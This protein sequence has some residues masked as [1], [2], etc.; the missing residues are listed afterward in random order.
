MEAMALDA[1]ESVSVVRRIQPAAEIVPELAG[2]AAKLLRRR[3]SPPGSI[4]VV[5]R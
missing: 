1:G 3:A 5:P 2:A 4:G